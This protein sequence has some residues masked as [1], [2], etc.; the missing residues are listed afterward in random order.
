MR[1]STS[2]R[3][4]YPDRVVLVFG[5]ETEGLPEVIRVKHRE[6]MVGIPM[7][8]PTLRSLNLSTSVG[9]L[10]YEVLRQWNL[11]DRRLPGRNRDAM[12]TR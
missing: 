5:Q 9:I 4:D 10:L 8:D 2:G 12:K 7:H 3:V 1:R 6:H 11:R